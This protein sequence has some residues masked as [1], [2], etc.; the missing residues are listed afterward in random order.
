MSEIKYCKGIFRY[1]M[2]NVKQVGS[3][4]KM[5]IKDEKNNCE[6]DGRKKKIK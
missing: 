2:I 5:H 6:G 4:K 3:S 1:F